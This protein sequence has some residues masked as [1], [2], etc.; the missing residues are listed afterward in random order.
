M[1]VYLKTKGEEILLAEPKN[2]KELNEYIN[3]YFNNG[4]GCHYMRHWNADN[5]H[6]IDFGSHTDF[7]FI[8]GE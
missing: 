2:D 6:W 8:K 4:N 3:E 1:K 5:R 7:L